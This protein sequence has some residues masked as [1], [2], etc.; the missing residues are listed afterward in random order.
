VDRRARS[1]WIAIGLLVGCSRRERPD[2]L[3]V[4][5]DTT[6]YDHF[7][8]TGDP[9]GHTPTVDGLAARGLLFAHTYASVALTLPSH[10]TI[11]TGLEPLA[12]GVHENGR[13][14]VPDA[15]DTLAERLRASG[16]Q[17]AAFVSA[18][19]LDRRFG[20]A[21]GF[22]AYDDETH[23]PGGA[24]DL[25]VPARAGAETTDAA[26]A[27][28]RDRSADRP[29]FLWA[30][31]YDPHLPRRVAPAFE[32][33]RDRYAAAIASADAEFGRLLAGIASLNRGRGLL[34]VFTADHGEALD[35]HGE[36]THGILGYDST[37]HVPLVVAGAG[38][39]TGRRDNVLARHVDV[40]PTILT[41]VGL[42]VPA[43]LPGRDLV[44][45]TADDGAVGYF[46]S[47]GPHLDYGWAVIE[48]VRTL[49]W[50][51]TARPAPAE[52]YDVLRDPRETAS[53]IDAEPA[54]ATEMAASL[55]ALRSRAA[56]VTGAPALT[57]SLEER[58]RLA[59]LGYVDAPQEHPP[60]AELDP[61][62]LAALHDWVDDA[63]W[64]ATAGR[65]DEAIEALETL[66]QSPSV[67]AFVLRTLAPVYAVRGRFD[68]AVAAYREY[69]RL[70]GAE[71]AYLGLGRTL[72]T[73]GQPEAAL[74]AID[75]APS[76]STTLLLRAHALARLGRHAEARAA[77]DAA[78]VARPDDRAR[79][80]KRATLVIDAAP[81][82]DGE[83]ELRG[84]VAAA[85]DDAALKSWLG[86]YLALWGRSDQRDEAHAL[87]VA[88]ARSLPSDADAQS[89]LG[90]GAARLGDDREAA[91]AL[92]AALRLDPHR[93]LERFRLAVVVQRTGESARARELVR[94]AL[95]EEPQASWAAPARA[96]LRQLEEPGVSLR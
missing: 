82:P 4:T 44:T 15:V 57:L 8:C 64:L 42:S 80:R 91:S 22:D 85:P 31:Y 81:V 18:F 32:A 34:V 38:V 40:V 86:Y 74:A 56:A 94:T 49:R 79:L 71:E 26:L 14:A 89:N 84:L 65:Y 6:R 95:A 21:Q 16:W 33:M 54:V 20:L 69:I 46:E 3:L 63:R 28:L 83:A 13:F 50:K 60:D 24:L 35:E 90:W 5:F 30:H 88:A 67:H 76:S 96:L 29:F 51:Y 27:W 48:G 9:E 45:A 92:E 66:A 72:L 55:A 75:G 39:P 59:A 11:L 2:V 70:T 36:R 12:H 10:T 77:V 62:R 78:F 1:Y 52:L 19:V 47:W 7:G 41:R 37:L 53:R 43:G 68:D 23:R 61:R 93:S 58:E 73:A 17:T 87:L 25:A